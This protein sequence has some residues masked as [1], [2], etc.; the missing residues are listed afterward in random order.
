LPNLDDQASFVRVHEGRDDTS[1][2]RPFS[3]AIARQKESV[4]MLVISRKIGQQVRIGDQITVTIIK[5]QGKTVRVGIEAPRELKILRTELP[6]LPA[7][8]LRTNNLTDGMEDAVGM[9]RSPGPSATDKSAGDRRR[10]GR[11]AM[12]RIPRT[13]PTHPQ[14]WTVATMRERVHGQG[15]SRPALAGGSRDWE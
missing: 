4:N 7:A 1:C 12:N 9:S 14:R 2:S 5:T 11:D 8:A 3:K 10:R 6:P 13:E 15:S